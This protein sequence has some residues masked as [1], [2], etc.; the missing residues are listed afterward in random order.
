M[1][2]LEKSTRAAGTAGAMALQQACAWV[3]EEQGDQGI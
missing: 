2:T 1:T 3:W